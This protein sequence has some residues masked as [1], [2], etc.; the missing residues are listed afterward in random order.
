MSTFKEIGA[1]DIKTSRS[2]L[3]QLVDVIQED[4]SGSATRRSYQVYV[5]GG[6][7][8]GVTSSLYQT[9]YDQDFSLQTANQLFD[10][11][12][13]LYFSGS[14]VT[15]ASTGLDSNG[16]Q[17]FPSQ[18][19]M[20][21]EKVSIYK[22]Y[23]AN[24]LG[25]ADEAFFTPFGSTLSTDRVDNA[26]FLSFKRLFTRDKMKR[27]TFAIKMYHSASWQGTTQATFR[28]TSKP[29]GRTIGDAL[30]GAGT[31]LNVTSILDARIYTDFGASQNRR[32]TFGGEV[33]DL[34]HSANAATKAGLIF[35]DAGAVVLNLS[36]VI[37]PTQPVSGVIDAMRAG[38]HRDVPTGKTVIGGFQ[39]SPDP[40]KLIN[41][42]SP[43]DL[44]SGRDTAF[45]QNGNAT[46]IPDLMVSGSIDDI[47]K[48]IATT[49]FSSGS[50]TAATFQNN[51]NINSTLIFCRASAD[52][53]NY[54][55][56]PTFTDSSNRVVVIDEGQEDTQ[57]TF[58]F[59][60]TVGLYDIN[61]N[62]LA[63]AKLSRPI[64]KNDEKDLTVRVRLDF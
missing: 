2:V 19:M 47:L 42:A 9:V 24:L 53:F 16:K 60:T 25:N 11:T 14:T 30:N 7:G 46:F 44:L 23:A 31:N 32:R 59:L 61:D 62:L 12:V 43:A 40:T 41:G 37:N 1:T 29:D 50:L 8:P 64:E 28:P 10:M 18:S 21:R 6:I 56:N 22:Q 54:S 5:T 63:V 35:Y 58:S 27:E 33:G 3:N 36:R 34:V 13:G 39:L 52:E 20:M 55:S 26:L 49:R 17:L 38:T 15:T 48:H 57:R 45:T 51:T 4:I